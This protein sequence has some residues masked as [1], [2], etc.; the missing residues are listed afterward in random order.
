MN[1]PNIVARLQSVFRDQF[2]DPTLIIMDETSSA[3]ILDWD[4]L[5]HIRLVI[6]VE[7]EF[8]CRFNTEELSELKNVGDMISAIQKK[9][10]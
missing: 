4:S 5:A 9:T 1:K 10:A 3:D 2:D 8:A 6:A 7:S